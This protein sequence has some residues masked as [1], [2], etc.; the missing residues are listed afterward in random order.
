[1]RPRIGSVLSTFIVLTASAIGGVAFLYPFFRPPV[2]QTVSFNAH[3][4]DA[5]Y[6]FLLITLS[7]LGAVLADLTWGRMSS[8]R[9]AV[10]GVLAALGAALRLIPGPGGFSAL[11]FLPIL[12]GY[13]YGPGFGFLLGTFTLIASALVTGGIGPWLPYQMLAA[14]WVGALAGVWGY[15]VRGLQG[16]RYPPSRWEVVGLAVWGGVLGLFYGAVMNLWFWPY[17]FQPQH[18]HMYW[19][20]GL[21]WKETLLRYGVFY[22]TTS[23][24][25]DMGRAA[26]NF[27][28]ILTVGRPVLRALYRFHARSVLDVWSA[29]DSLVAESQE[30]PVEL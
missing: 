10:L 25:W 5:L 2:Q 30:R 11:F 19:Q 4:E 9:T 28:L 12:A 29:E 6:L 21:S 8:Q 17:V 24:W 27:L 20:P 26:G 13:V 23:L 1:M 15:V 3:G 22:L 18:A 16:V 14:A 7:G